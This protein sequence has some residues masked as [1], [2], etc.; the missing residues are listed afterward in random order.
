MQYFAYQ[1]PNTGRTFLVRAGNEAEARRAAINYFRSKGVG[2]TD[3]AQLSGGWTV[4]AGEAENYLRGLP[5]A[6]IPSTGVGSGTSGG[7][8]S[9]SGTGIGGGGASDGG[10]ASVSG[11]G[12]NPS[13]IGEDT[14]LGRAA[15][16][17]RA[18]QM[19]GLPTGGFAGEYYNDQFDPYEA[20]FQG[21]LATNIAG[22][23]SQ[24]DPEAN[25]QLFSE[26]VRQ[27]TN[28]YGA[29]GAQ[30]RTLL[31]QNTVDAE[32]QPFAA[33]LVNPGSESLGDAQAFAQQAIQ[34]RLGGYA[35]SLLNPY[36]R[37]AS[38]S[39]AGQPVQVGTNAAPQQNYL[40]YLRTKLGLGGVQF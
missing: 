14:Q 32:A 38:V 28:P 40:Q 13:Y 25:Q 3:L 10:G 23:G 33:R 39:Y 26:Y 34:G 24:F 36:L 16:F 30:F 19:R 29:I 20:A 5:D 4:D 9:T 27:N 17:Q 22:I 18:L 6:L 8:G 7:T 11:F 31:G 12:T 15:S 1:D 37:R 2:A 21:E 35:A